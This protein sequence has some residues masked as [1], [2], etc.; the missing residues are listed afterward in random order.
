MNDWIETNFYTHY[1]D[2]FCMTSFIALCLAKLVISDSVMVSLK[3]LHESQKHFCFPCS[4]L[5]LI[6][7][8]SKELSYVT[9]QHFRF[10]SFSNYPEINCTFYY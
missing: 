10:Y 6:L 7:E 9:L 3:R 1:M 5:L 8:Y 2:V 4:L